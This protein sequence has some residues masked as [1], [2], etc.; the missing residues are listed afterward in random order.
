VATH[1]V[2]AAENGENTV[3]ACIDLASTGV[4]KTP[5]V[6]SLGLE[7][8]PRGA[9]ELRRVAVPKEQLL[10]TGTAALEAARAL[11]QTT[12]VLAAAAAVG[13]AG[14]ALDRALSHARADGKLSQSTEF[15]VSDLATGYDAA[16]LATARAAWLRDQGADAAAE[17]AGARL[18]AARTATE[19]CDGALRV[20][21]EA[22]YGDDLRRAYLDA[23]HLALYDGAE[24]AQIDVIAKE[25]LGES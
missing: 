1:V 25:M 21:G 10:L 6:P 12:N 4:A 19:L 2:L 16:W 5:A 7:E 14:R 24:T 20:C 8:L 11:S 15:I 3:F 17:S 13:V 23:R 22:G 9:L 18:L